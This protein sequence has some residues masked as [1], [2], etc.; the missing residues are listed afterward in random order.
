MT[1]LLGQHFFVKAISQS[2]PNYVANALATAGVDACLN[3]L[4]DDLNASLG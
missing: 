4:V 3:E 2:R 1:R